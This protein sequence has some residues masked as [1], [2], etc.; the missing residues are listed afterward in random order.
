MPHFKIIFFSLN[1]ATAA[2]PLVGNQPEGKMSVRR[3][4]QRL[5]GYESCG[6]SIVITYEFKGGVQ[7]PNHPNPGHRYTGTTRC[8]YLPDNAEGQKVLKLLRKA[9]DQKLTFTIGRSSTSGVDNIITW[10]DIHH[11]TSVTGGPT[12]YV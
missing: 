2:S 1:T 5:P 9:F 3:S 6:G 7:G 11:K 4:L 12:K 8:G 10:N